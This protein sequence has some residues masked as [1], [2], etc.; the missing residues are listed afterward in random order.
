[1]G[2]AWRARCAL[3][4]LTALQMGCEGLQ[5]R[6]ILNIGVIQA[7]AGSQGVVPGMLQDVHLYI[8]TTIGPC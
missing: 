4:H 2:R 3:E 8:L 1:M 7:Q 5:V 6:A